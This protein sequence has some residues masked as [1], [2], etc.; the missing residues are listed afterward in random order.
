ML[1]YERLDAWKV[2][3]QLALGVYRATAAYPADERYGLTSQSR[4]AAASAAANL[5]E[6]SAKRGAREFRRYVD[7]SLGSL[8]ELAYLLLLARDLQ[9][10]ADPVWQELHTL[11]ERAGLLVWR[12]YQSLGRPRNPA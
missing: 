6:G 5:A 8:A 7:I 12:L 9:L 10:L 11:R 3:H 4:R 2:C 1:P